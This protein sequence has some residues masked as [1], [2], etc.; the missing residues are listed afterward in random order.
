MAPDKLKN[1]AQCGFTKFDRRLFIYKVFQFAF[2]FSL[3]L[4]IFS[5]SLAQL[6]AS[7]ATSRLALCWMWDSP[8]T[9]CVWRRT[10]IYT[11]HEQ[12]E[13]EWA[14]R[15]IS[16]LPQCEALRTCRSGFPIITKWCCYVTR[17]WKWC[18]VQPEPTT[19]GITAIEILQSTRFTL[20]YLLRIHR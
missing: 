17:M 10:P 13:I 9:R 1:G 11:W 3:S 6:V 19:L 20:L 16:V 14:R 2:Y 8:R 4:S 5:T 18:Q 12:A 7:V 15:V